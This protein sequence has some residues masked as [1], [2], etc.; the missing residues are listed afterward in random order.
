M[1]SSTD[2]QMNRVAFGSID[3][4]PCA[5]FELLKNAYDAA[6][7]KGVP[8]TVGSVFTADQNVYNAVVSIST[9]STPYF[10]SFSI[11]ESSL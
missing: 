8:V 3:F 4:A 6:K 10:A 1:T 9:P 2:S 7:D 5:D 11:C